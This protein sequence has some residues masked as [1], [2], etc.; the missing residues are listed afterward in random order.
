M[1]LEPVIEC[2][3][4]EELPRVLSVDPDILMINNRPIAALPEEPGD[5]YVQGSVTV[6]LDWWHRNEALRKWKERPGRLLISASCINSHKD[7]QTLMRVPCDACL[8]GNS[9]MTATNCVAFLQSLTSS[10]PV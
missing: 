7:I 3:L 4:E 1:G 10:Q 8:V 9:A 6:T 2:S 5:S